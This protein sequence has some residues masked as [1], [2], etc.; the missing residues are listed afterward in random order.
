M[1]HG[2]RALLDFQT[3]QAIP[4]MTTGGGLVGS[5][6]PG[7][8]LTGNPQGS[9]LIANNPA[10][11]SANPP[12]VTAVS[13]GSAFGT[14]QTGNNFVKPHIFYFLGQIKNEIFNGH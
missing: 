4:L 8:V 14:I 12:L 11:T 10:A 9:A 2:V 5:A 7:T 6:P 3:N 13:G 1:L